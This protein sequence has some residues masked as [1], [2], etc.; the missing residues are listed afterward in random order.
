[1]HAHS[2]APHVETHKLTPYGRPI[3]TEAPHHILVISDQ[4]FWL[5]KLFKALTRSCNYG[6]F[7]SGAAC[8]LK[9]K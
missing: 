1:M 3:L 5:P 7:W 4:G 6:G 2:Q 9:L 8:M